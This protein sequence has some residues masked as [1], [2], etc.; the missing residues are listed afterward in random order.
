MKI[1][2]LDFQKISDLRFL[3]ISIFGDFENFDF[4]QIFENF[5]I[6]MNI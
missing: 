2:N 3:K 6:S 1:E 4:F 5:K